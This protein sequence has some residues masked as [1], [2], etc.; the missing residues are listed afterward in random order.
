MTYPFTIYHKSYH[1]RHIQFFCFYHNNHIIHYIPFSYSH[2]PSH[3]RIIH[4]QSNYFV[5]CSCFA[6]PSSSLSLS[7]YL[8][9]I[10]VSSILVKGFPASVYALLLLSLSLSLTSKY[11]PSVSL[12]HLGFIHPSLSLSLSLFAHLVL[13]RAREEAQ[14][15]TEAAEEEEEEE[16]EEKEEHLLAAAKDFGFESKL[17]LW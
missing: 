12:S 4:I 13:A 5:S 2:N 17:C 7:P 6:P 1:P 8:L 9:L 16:E 3:P 10:Q 11:H 15:E 14:E